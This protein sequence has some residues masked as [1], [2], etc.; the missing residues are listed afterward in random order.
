MS[1]HIAGKNTI[2]IGYKTRIAKE[3]CYRSKLIPILPLSVR[4]GSYFLPYQ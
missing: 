4:H 3:R 1:L 2:V